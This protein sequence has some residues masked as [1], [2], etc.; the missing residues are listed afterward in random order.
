M[1]CRSS[2]LAV[3]ALSLAVPAAFAQVGSSAAAFADFDIPAQALDQALS[4]FARQAGLQLLAAPELLRGLRSQPLSGRRDTAGALAELLRGSGLRGRIEGG[5]LVI[6]PAAGAHILSEVR[7]SATGISPSE[8]PAAYAGGQVASGARLGVLGNV[9]V[10]DAPFNITA[11]TAQTIADQQ[12]ATVAEV[13]RND[14]S[15][16]YTTSDGHNAENFTIRGFDLTSTEL[17]FNGLYNML[18]G[19][20]VP[21]EFLERV[22][23]FKGPGA[24]L[25]GIAP[26]GAVGGVINLVPKRAGSEP[27][28]R[29]TASYASAFRFG[30]AADLGRRFG[31]EQRLGVRVNA[32]SSDGETTLE[33]QK[34]KERFLSLG[35]DYRGDGWRLELDAYSSRQDQSNGSPLWVGFT[36]LGH[37]LKAPDPTR[38]ALRGTYV[39]Q[40]TEGV[41]LRGEYDLNAHWTAWAAVG[42]SR[43]RYKGYLNGTLVEVLND[44]GDARGQTNHQQGFTK[45][46]SAEAGVRGS[47]TTGAVAHQLVASASSVQMR[48]SGGRVGLTT[49]AAYVTNIYEPIPNPTLAGPYGAVWT[50]VDNTYTSFSLADTLS[51]RNDAVL[52][53]L[54][55]RAQRVRQSMATPTA[56]DESAVTPL[57][58]LVLKPWGPA[59]SLYANYIEGLSPGIT[60]G[61]TYANAGET[62][63][64]YRTKQAEV[65][66]KW[67]AGLGDE[68]G[69]RF[70]NTLSLFQIEK[71]FAV[72]VATGAPLPTLKLDG[73]QRNRGVEWNVF[74][75]VG[76]GV[77]LLG[78]G[79]Y[80]QA[81]QVRASST[82][83]DGKDMPGVPKWTA[84]LGAEWDAPLLA[85]LTLSA[86]WIYTSSQYLDV[87]NR[88]EIPAWHRWDIGARYATRIA[89]KAVVVRASVENLE[90]R[91]YWSGRFYPGGQATLGAPRTFKLSTSVDF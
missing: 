7:V 57:L 71:P 5:T 38:N 49:G 29:L 44:A 36:T 78:G 79:A 28:T 74:G 51:M 3:A 56:Y 88:L 69:V 65:G 48:S 35:M 58:G 18:P 32:S 63:T 19:T 91:H 1:I 50:T 40:Q 43:Y 83:N 73:E 90:D 11:Y 72:S 81:E 89:G 2:T 23:V 62:L 47:F 55:A 12:S 77:R 53:T 75:E 41:A 70:T 31:E 16:R 9:D 4:A 80:T 39:K 37:V 8:L 60:V 30:I 46:L 87:A 45:G 84:N 76:K 61:V 42:G 14:P 26:S 13:L 6:E 85:G 24:M 68:N 10:M 59:V 54:G 64:P 33:D 20:H 17:A 15:V 82:A 86:R 22:E 21:T 67:E 52:L 27:L 66:I 34:K 25:S